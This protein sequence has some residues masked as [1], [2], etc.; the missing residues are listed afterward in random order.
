[1]ILKSGRQSKA[2]LIKNISLEE[3]AFL[4][5]ISLS[6]F[7][8][9][10]EKIYGMSPSKWMLQKRMEIAKDLLQ[11]YNEKPG[12][13]YHQVGYENHSSFSQS[14]RQIFG[15]TPKEF[16]RQQLNGKQQLLTEKP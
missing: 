16:Q 14:F 15:V 7:K 8:R 13:V 6:T 4:C 11:H 1:M 3:L 2:N 5:N 12:E 10:F 9:R